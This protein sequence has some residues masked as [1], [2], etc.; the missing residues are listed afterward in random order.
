MVGS[1]PVKTRSNSH[2]YAIKQVTAEHAMIII[3][4]WWLIIIVTWQKSASANF[5]KLLK[6]SL[7]TELLEQIDNLLLRLYQQQQYG[8]IFIP[9]YFAIIHSIPM[10]HH[11]IGQG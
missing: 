7:V 10:L 1:K 3:P 6:W 9:N 2:Q 8:T 4:P 5:F 11:A